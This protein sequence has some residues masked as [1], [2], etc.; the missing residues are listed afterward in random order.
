[1]STDSPS[2]ATPDEIIAQ[3]KSSKRK[4][5]IKVALGIILGLIILSAIG[6]TQGNNQSS[7][8]TSSNA[9]TQ[10]VDSS[11]VPSGFTQWVDDENLAWRWATKAETNCTYSSGACWAAMVV[12][13]N[14]CPS[15]LYGEINIFDKNDIQIS[16]TNDT[17]SSVQPNQKVRLTF[18]T[19]SEEDQS[20]RMSKFSC[21]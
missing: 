14:G 20:A 12:S 8:P 19:F 11:W 5:R 1:M 9:S 6:S 15:N 16:Y 3:Y 21:Y 7:S 4:K 13:K 2:G 10:T 18:D 17:L